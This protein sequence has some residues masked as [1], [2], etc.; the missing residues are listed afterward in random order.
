MKSSTNCGSKTPYGHITTPSSPRHDLLLLEARN[1]LSHLCMS[2][3][4]ILAMALQLLVRENH[5]GQDG[6]RE[7]LG[8]HHYLY[9]YILYVQRKNLFGSFWV[10]QHVFQKGIWFAFFKGNQSL[11]LMI[12][13][14][15]RSIFSMS[16]ARELQL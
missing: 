2:T 3:F 8:Q 5:G 4:M 1:V 15:I 6:S 10:F 14:R 7:T 11:R 9:I 16:M 12:K 13:G